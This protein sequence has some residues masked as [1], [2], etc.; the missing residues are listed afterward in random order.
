MLSQTRLLNLITK[1]GRLDIAFEPSGTRGYADLQ[2][3]AKDVDIGGVTIRVAS[4]LD[5]IRSKEAAGRAKDRGVL[6]VLRQMLD[7]FGEEP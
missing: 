1:F 2:K 7:R 5:I 4:L 6:Y 3:N